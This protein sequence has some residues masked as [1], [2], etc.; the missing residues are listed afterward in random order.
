[1]RVLNLVASP[2]RPSVYSCLRWPKALAT[3]D[4]GLSNIESDP[5]EVSL[6]QKVI[7]NKPAGTADLCLAS[8]DQTDGEIIDV[9]LFSDACPV[10]FR[11]SPRQIEGGPL[12]ENISKCQVKPPSL[13]D[14]DYL[15]G[16]IR[17]MLWLSTIAKTGPGVIT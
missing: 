10:K 15:G 14:L 1:M 13:A 12:S 9:G 3:M 4:K 2:Q 16:S 6:E 17:L 8:S 7:N 5:S 11:N